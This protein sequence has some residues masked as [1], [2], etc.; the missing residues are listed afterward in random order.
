V[1]AGTDFYV[2]T[3]SATANRWG[4]YSSAAVD[5]VDGCFWIANKHAITRGTITNGTQDGRW[6][7]ALARFC[8]T[9][10]GL[11]FSNGFEP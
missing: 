8:G 1:R 2:R 6:G 9:P 7:T 3:F 10:G 4:D 11:I 5:P